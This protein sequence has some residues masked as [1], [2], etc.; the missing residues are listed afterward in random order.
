MARDD[1]DIHKPKAADELEAAL[2][3]ILGA[4]EGEGP[5]PLKALLEG[6]DETGQAGAKEDLGRL[7]DDVYAGGRRLERLGDCVLMVA[8]D[9]MRAFFRGKLP[10]GFT[11]EEAMQVLERHGICFGV[12]PS[13]VYEALPRRPSS[14][15]RER[16]GRAAAQEEKRDFVVA[17]GQPAVPPGEDRLEYLCAGEGLEKLKEVLEGPYFEAVQNC[18]LS[19]P[20]VRPGQELARLV[21]QEGRPGRN[22]FGQEIPAG[23]APR[24]ELKV[25]ENAALGQDGR[26]CLAR[27]CG[28]AGLLEGAISVLPPIWISRDLMRVC[29][30]FLPQQGGF[31]APEK[32]C[33]DALLEE[34]G[35]VH[36]IDEKA[37]ESLCARLQKGEPVERATLIARGTEAVPGKDAEWKFPFAP[38]LTRYFGEIRRILNRSPSVEYLVEYSQGLA[39][40]AASAG[41][42]LAWKE[43]AAAGQVGRDVFGEEFL[44][45]EPQDASLEIGPHL[46]FSE[47]GA[48][49]FAEVYGY[50]GLGQRRLEMVSPLWVAPDRMAAYFVNLPSLG[51]R[52]APIAEE[53]DQ[54]LKLAGVQYGIDAR[55]MGALCERLRQGLP[56]PIAV[57]LAQ[58]RPPQHG[59]DDRFEFALDVERKPGIFREDGSIDFRQL[60]LAPLV[61]AGQAL[62]RRFPAGQG[63][64]GTDV[65]GREV[66][67]RN[68]TELVV[69]TGRNVRRVQQEGQPDEF[70]AE[71]EGELGIIDRRDRL[72]PSL[73]LAVREK[74][75]VQGDVDYGTGNIDFPGSVEVRGTVKPG[76]LVRAEGDVVVGEHVEAGAQIA[77]TGNLAVRYGISGATTRVEAKGSVFARFVNAAQVRAGEDLVIGEYVYNAA[78]R[79]GKTLSV[80]GQS[81]REPSGSIVGGTAMAGALI[82]ARHIGSEGGQPARLVAGVDAALLGEAAAL[83]KQID[84]YNAVI[85]KVLR[86]L[87]I[88][89]L[90]AKQVRHVLLT[91][92][93]KAKGP[94]RKILAQSVRNLMEMQKRREQV[95]A[96]QKELDARLEE[97]AARAAIEVEG[98]VAPKTVVKIGGCA[99]VAGPET[100]QIQS[101]R[102]SLG[103][104]EGKAQIV[105][106]AL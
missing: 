16:R 65:W 83:Q 23:Q 36:G 56:T 99:L 87:E 30:V 97:A 35:M 84:Q 15:R 11:R 18:R 24:A 89:R 3:G 102:F 53:I 77:C 94:R 55:A 33:L 31:A 70:V 34:L 98:R 50:V 44:P 7:M 101:V 67:A 2:E 9:D 86:A 51:D 40:K 10:D 76:F 28:Y 29:F 106:R 96:R 92:V 82:R 81:G 91:L 8:E 43:P 54:L 88:E 95:L 27:I 61:K 60:N 17:E 41:Q 52:P 6:V 26:Q 79:A 62:G 68:G 103:K 104:R 45:E 38:E 47:D 25:G 58:G 59:E 19:L 74:M 90:D 37:I 78:V 69:E 66:P 21:G 72:P 105:M 13:G 93:L 1:L 71:V 22:V 73:Y 4:G 75:V 57:C 12:R 39:G 5:N 42:K 100:G 64:P 63:V 80:F 85:A 20:L 14:R 46:R 49:C 48:E 32:E